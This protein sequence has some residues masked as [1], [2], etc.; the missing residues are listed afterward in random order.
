M[1]WEYKTARVIVTQ[2]LDASHPG[3]GQEKAEREAQQL[4]LDDLISFGEEGWE[5]VSE[6]VILSGPDQQTVVVRHLGTL[7]RPA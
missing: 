7:K 3:S 2:R 6:Q 5:L 4:W 1:K